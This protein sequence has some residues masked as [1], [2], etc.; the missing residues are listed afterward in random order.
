MYSPIEVQLAHEIAERLSDPHSVTQYLKYAKKYPHKILR[1][2]LEYVCS[3]PDT[4]ITNSRGAYFIFLVEQQLRGNKGE[5]FNNW[6][7]GHTG[8]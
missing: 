5:R 3:L 4:K 8:Y 6:N 2:K 7:N 1:E